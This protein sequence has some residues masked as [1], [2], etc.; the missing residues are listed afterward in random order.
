MIASLVAG[1]AQAPDPA[2]DSRLQKSAQEFEAMLLRDLMKM[3][4]DDDE[5]GHDPSLEAYEDLRR[6]AVA[7]AMAVTSG[8]G[9]ARML[10]KTM[11]GT[12]GNAQI[13]VSSSDA[14]HLIATEY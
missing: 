3:A 13:K 4:S 8:V 1:P 5:Q 11:T 9:I 6:E 2:I 7:S 12:G 10:L 14:D